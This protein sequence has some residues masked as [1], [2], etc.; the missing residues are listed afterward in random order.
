MKNSDA[1][2]KSFKTKAEAL[3]KAYFK[4]KGK[5][6]VNINYFN[7]FISNELSN[8]VKEK[9]ERKPIIIPIIMECTYDNLSKM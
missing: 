5:T 4:A 2:M 8:F 3:F 7:I 1:L 6:S 9:T